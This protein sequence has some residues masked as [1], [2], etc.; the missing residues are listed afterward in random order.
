MQSI[1]IHFPKSVQFGRIITEEKVKLS[2]NFILCI[3]ILCNKKKE[4]KKKKRLRK[5]YL[6]SMRLDNNNV[7][8]AFGFKPTKVFV[9]IAQTVLHLS[10]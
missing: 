7:K 1:Y 4:G 6:Q 8:I 5:N 9:S 10:Y 3:D 2:Y